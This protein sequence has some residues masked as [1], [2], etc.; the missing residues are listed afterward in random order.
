MTVIGAPTATRREW[1][2]GRLKEARGFVTGYEQTA[3]SFL[4]VV[5]LLAALD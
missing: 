5:H 4:V 1:F 3:A 2:F